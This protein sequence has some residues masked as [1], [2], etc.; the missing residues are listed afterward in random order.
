MCIMVYLAADEPLQLLEW[1]EMQPGLHAS[2][3]A[4]NEDR[5]RVQFTKGTLV[6]AG[7]YEGC[8]CGFQNGEYGPEHYEPEELRQGRRSL[9]EFSEYLR[10]ELPRVGDIELFACWDGDQMAPPEHRR[11]LTPDALK[12]ENFF[13]IQKEFSLIIRDAG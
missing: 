7:S 12:S 2:L 5:V 3:P 9:Y 4:P 1:N 6:Y 8:G 10:R 11:T 13:F